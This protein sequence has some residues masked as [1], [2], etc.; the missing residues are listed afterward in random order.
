MAPISVRN[1]HG[2]APP[3]AKPATRRGARRPGSPH[4]RHIVGTLLAGT[5]LA[6]PAKAGAATDC[7]AVSPQPVRVA[8]IAG[9]AAL[10][11]TDGRTVALAGLIVPPGIA[12]APERAEA[13][14]ARA[15]LLQP[16]CVLPLGPPDRWNRLPAE[17]WWARQTCDRALPA[18]GP[19][20]TLVAQGL[21][22]LMPAALPCPQASAAR[23]ATAEETA[24]QAGRGLWAPG[25]GLVQRADDP[26]LA[27]K[28]GRFAVVEGQVRS[29]GMAGK[30]FF[31]N[32]GVRWIIDFT[33][34][35]ADT[36]RKR[37]AAAGLDPA[38]L[39]GR[40]V[41]VRGWLEEKDGALM[42]LS[43]PGAMALAGTGGP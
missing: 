33:V 27:R 3:A 40:V 8:G 28:A 24:R 37:F 6:V 22:V 13:G 36:D 20:E 23:L 41:R 39:A 38:T 17:I 35:I 2:P 34:T 9:P 4:T 19:A 21:A 30:T 7:P 31:L 15:A 18:D 14:L 10:Q 1:G 43:D 5:L 16:V 26:H 25:M 32:F 42:V 29:V 12:G 11:L